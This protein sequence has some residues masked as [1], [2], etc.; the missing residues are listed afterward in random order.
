M[1]VPIKRSP[2]KQAM[3]E[4]ALAELNIPPSFLEA[5]AEKIRN[6]TYLNDLVSKEN[7]IKYLINQKEKIPKTLS[8]RALQFMNTRKRI[9]DGLLQIIEDDALEAPENSLTQDEQRYKDLQEQLEEIE[10]HE[11]SLSNPARGG[12]RIQ[13]EIAN[14][15]E[16]KNEIL[17][18]LALLQGRQTNESVLEDLSE[19]VPE[20][21]PEVAREA[22]PEAALHVPEPL[23]VT[24]GNPCDVLYDPCSG[25]PLE[26]N[27]LQALEKRV[28]EIRGSLSDNPETEHFP[29]SIKSR[30]D[31]LIHLLNRGEPPNSNLFKYTINGQLYEAYWDIVF[32]LNLID[33]FQRT[34]DFY[35]VD[36]KAE[37]IQA[38][39]SEIYVN[40]PIEYLRKRNV[41]EGASGASDIT[42]CYKKPKEVVAEDSCSASPVSCVA[43]ARP[44][45]TRMRFYFCSSKFYKKD[46]SKSAESFDI[47]K[48]YTA[49]KK[50]HSDYDVRIILL[51]KDKNAVD[52]KLKNARNKYISDEASKVYGEKDLFAAL[53]KLY[54]LAH[55][56]IKGTITEQNLKSVLGITDKIKPLLSPRL[57]QHMAILKIQKA[58]QK[59]KTSG[60]NNKFLVGI[61]PRGGKT[62]IAGGIVSLLQ[63]RRVVVLPVS[64]THLTLPTI[65]SV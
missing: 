16:R 21:A 30:L 10:R 28:R 48:I 41:N 18:E 35:M 43:S 45:D 4:A 29:D 25:K 53:L 22:V 37:L 39:E 42:F 5:Y 34:D 54:D 6:G 17:S 52:I 8:G 24:S 13:N 63:P 44:S 36:K 20:V 15:R 2:A 65:Y 32:S 31:L 3:V 46:A 58:I 47:Q 23:H 60:G 62:Y 61:L 33:E 7:D 1:E 49:V 14:V 57:H 51:V 50:L 26:V 19:E 56:K 27:T 55:Q 9:I 64:Y 38:S 40:N 59:F 12:G 11:E